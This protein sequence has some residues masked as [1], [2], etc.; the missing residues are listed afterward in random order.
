MSC[1]LLRCYVLLA[2][3]ACK[4]HFASATCECR[5][6]AGERWRRRDVFSTA[7]GDSARI[8]AVLVA[9]VALRVVRAA[10]LLPRCLSALAFPD[11]TFFRRSNRRRVEVAHRLLPPPVCVFSL[12][13]SISLC[14]SPTRSLSLSPTLF[15]LSVSVSLYL[16]VSTLFSLFALTL[17]SNS[18]FS[19]FRLSISQSLFSLQS[20]LHKSR[21]DHAC[22]RV[23]GPGGRFL[24]KAELNQYRKQLEAQD[25]E[26]STAPAPLPGAGRSK[27]VRGPVANFEQEQTNTFVF[28]N[29]LIDRPMFLDRSIRSIGR[30]TDT[31]VFFFRL[32]FN[33]KRVDFIEIY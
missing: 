19:L 20:F 10:S 23:R 30:G 21:H 32:K 6:L 7:F 27:Q 15:S 13:L 26:G 11:V 12:S 25:P 9:D 5:H 8:W 17:F 14:L 29:K 4:W 1:M 33:A 24:T 18:V 16:S 22:R 3:A 2:S 28:F 31:S